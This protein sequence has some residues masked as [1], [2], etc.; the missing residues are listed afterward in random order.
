L[1]KLGSIDPGD[2]D[3]DS[4]KTKGISVDHLRNAGSD[5]L[6]AGEIG[7][8]GY[9]RDENESG[10]KTVELAHRRASPPAESAAS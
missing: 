5:L 4:T 1:P 8:D 9:E 10:G 2:P 3:V 7:G 6:V